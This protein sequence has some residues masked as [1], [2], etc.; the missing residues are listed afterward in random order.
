MW[1]QPNLDTYRLGNYKCVSEYRHEL[2]SMVLLPRSAKVTRLE[3]RDKSQLTLS[4]EF[5]S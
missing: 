1:E 2:W 3:H 4:A 5:A